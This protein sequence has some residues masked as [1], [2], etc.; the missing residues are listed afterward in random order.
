[1]QDEK[2]LGVAVIDIGGG[3]TDM[4]F[5]YDG[6]IRHAAVLAVGGN[7][8]TNDVAVGLRTP[9]QEAERIKKK[10]GCVMISRIRGDEEIE[11]GFADGK[12]FRNIPRR[13]LVEILQPRAEELFGIL[14]D[15]IT[16]GGFQKVLNSGVVLTGGTAAMEGMDTMAENIL[17]LPVRTGRPAGFDGADDM[18][19]DPAFAAAAGLAIYCAEE[20]LSAAVSGNGGMKAKMKGWYEE[21]SKIFS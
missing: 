19:G 3:T 13:H 6:S 18:K 10:Y 9:A 20:S 15:E 7:N 14:K 1:T 12:L 8:F 2:D 4:A 21:A 16:A 17:E 5:Y 11:L